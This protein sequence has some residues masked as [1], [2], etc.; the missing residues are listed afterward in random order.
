[1]RRENGDKHFPQAVPRVSGLWEP[2]QIITLYLK[3]F[4]CKIYIGNHKSSKNIL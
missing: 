2:I 1:M 3:R 4:I